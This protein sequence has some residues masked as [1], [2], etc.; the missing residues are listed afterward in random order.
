MAAEMSV[1]K[2]ETKDRVARAESANRQQV[3]NYC[4]VER[5]ARLRRTVEPKASPIMNTGTKNS[6]NFGVLP[7]PLGSMR[8]TG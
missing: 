2:W 7:D 6:K 4:F 3:D 8:I 1:G 5:M